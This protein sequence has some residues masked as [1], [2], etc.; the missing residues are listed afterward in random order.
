MTAKSR[1]SEHLHGFHEVTYRL[2][3]EDAAGSRTIL[4]FP[5]VE[6]LCPVIVCMS[7]GHAACADEV[8]LREPKGVVPAPVVYSLTDYGR[9]LLPLVEN[10]RLWGRGHLERLNE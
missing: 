7:F 9:S 10:V 2:L 5:L 4:S 1:L 8:V 6:G 3:S